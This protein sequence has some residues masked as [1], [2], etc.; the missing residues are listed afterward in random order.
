M[1]M[2][3]YTFKSDIKDFFE[4]HSKFI[5]RFYWVAI[6]TITVLIFAIPIG[7]G[8]R[9]PNVRLPDF[10][11]PPPPELIQQFNAFVIQE[12]R[13]YS[14]LSDFAHMV[15]R[16]Y[17]TYPYFEQVT[18]EQGVNFMELSV[19]VF[20][21]LTGYARYEVTPRFFMNFVI[22]QYLSVLGNI[23]GLRL[24]TEPRAMVD[25][26]T[27]PYYF[28][29][30]DPRFYDDRF[31]VPVREGNITT[32]NLADIIMYLRINNFLPKG[33]E[34]VTRA[35]FWYFCFDSD[36]EYL[37]D[38]FNNLYGIDDLIIDIRGNGSGFGDYFVPLI[39]ASHLREP[40]ST[41]F[42]AF[43]AN[44]P[45]PQRVSDAYRAWYGITESTDMDVLTQGFVYDLPEIVTLGFQIEKSIQPVG[46][47]TFDGRI[48]LITDSDNFSGP[49]LVYLQMAREAGFTVV[50]EETPDSIGWATSFFL[51]PYS[52]LS[53]RFNPLYFTDVTGESFE[54]IG[55][56]Y[57]YL[58]SDFSEMF[59]VN[60]PQ[61]S[62]D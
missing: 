41:I 33:Y 45:F 22:D 11:G 12:Q 46:D 60:L 44:A 37:T 61:L 34:L 6:V 30:H 10:H 16:L 28:G 29:H 57:D 7:M 18:H 27:Q 49:N 25:W 56:V 21:E 20:D 9:N 2:R 52:G 59:D 51:L 17:E 35:P 55:A 58:F 53:V 42:Y 3:W 47:T 39:L 15:N 38:L 14:R 26:I 8:I 32:E 54:R 36:R 13:E 5:R 24:T 19:N 50:Y 48:W 62:E 40:V 23:G 43:Y 1:G 31:Y 4:R